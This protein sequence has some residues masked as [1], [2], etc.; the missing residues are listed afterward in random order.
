MLSKKQRVSVIVILMVVAVAIAF[1]AWRVFLYR[2]TVRKYDLGYPQINLGDS[3]Q[4]VLRLMGDPTKITDCQ[5]AAFPDK[6]IEDEYRTKCKEQYRYEV[7]FKDYI[8]S[9]D[10]QETVLAKNSAVSP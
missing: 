9:F 4:V 3:K 10:K 5:Y 7:F 2:E 8:I 1:V 6:K